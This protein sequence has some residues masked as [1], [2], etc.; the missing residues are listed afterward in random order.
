MINSVYIALIKKHNKYSE[1]PM[2]PFHRSHL[3]PSLQR[4][5]TLVTALLHL[6]GR[7]SSWLTGTAVTHSTCIHYTC[8][9]TAMT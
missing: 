1:L 4:E 3:Y 5:H 6:G 8:V 2:S 9:Y 7:G